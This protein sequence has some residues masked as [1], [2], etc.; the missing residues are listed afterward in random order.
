MYSKT[1]WISK[2]YSKTFITF[3]SHNFSQDFE[4]EG[5]VSFLHALYTLPWLHH[6]LNLIKVAR[7]FTLIGHGLIMACRYLGYRP[8]SVVVI[9][10]M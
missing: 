7:L 10:K 8:Y 4:N 3:C 1:F 9:E 5:G 2:M 6:W